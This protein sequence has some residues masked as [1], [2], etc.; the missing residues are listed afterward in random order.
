[1]MLSDLAIKRP[2]L[3]IVS[4]LLIVVFGIASLL[5]LPVRELPD[6]DYPTVTVSVGYA[7]AAPSVI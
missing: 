4:S 3:A 6:I 1:M 7:G 2:V 5:S